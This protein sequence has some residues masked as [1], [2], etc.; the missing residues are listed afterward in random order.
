MRKI[1]RFSIFVYVLFSIFTKK[2]WKFH[3]DVLKLNSKSNVPK[4][5]LES[6]THLAIF[7][8]LTP[9]KEHIKHCIFALTAR[10]AFQRANFSS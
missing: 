5:N 3:Y 6:I 10:S 8:V 1:V 9:A 7:E 4:Q 2:I